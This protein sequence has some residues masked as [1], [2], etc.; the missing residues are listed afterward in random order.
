MKRI[1][2]KEILS[3]CGVIL[4]M[5]CLVFLLTV[6]VGYSRAYSYHDPETIASE[7]RPSV[8]LMGIPFLADWA[9]AILAWNHWIGRR[10]K[11][12]RRQA[13]KPHYITAKKPRFSGRFMILC[14]AGLLALN[15]VIGTLAF[16]PRIELSRSG[17][18]AQYNMLD[19]G[20]TVAR[21]SQYDAC[22]V[23]AFYDLYLGGRTTIEKCSIDLTIHADGAEY[24]FT[25]GSVTSNFRDLDTMLDFID[26][27]DPGIL[28]FTGTEHLESYLARAKLTPE[29]AERIRE[30]FAHGSGGSGNTNPEVG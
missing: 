16:F 15:A 20:E 25:E 2:D 22:E 18:I 6:W 1:H 27:I 7:V 14:V 8:F 12:S 28:T 23:R 5:V 24:S 10:R 19:R 29:Q 17:E 9:A 13:K 21:R 11:P 4:S 26:T 3:A 30:M